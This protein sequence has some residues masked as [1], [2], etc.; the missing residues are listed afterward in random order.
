MSPARSIVPPVAIS[1]PAVRLPRHAADPRNRNYERCSPDIGLR[2]IWY[3]RL[4]RAI[5]MAKSGRAV[6]P[7]AFASHATVTEVSDLSASPDLPA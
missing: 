4:P 5:C 2:A 3:N 6:Y 7:V 1:T